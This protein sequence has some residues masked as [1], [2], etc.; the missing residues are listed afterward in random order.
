MAEQDYIRRLRLAMENGTIPKDQVGIFATDVNHE[1]DC[2]VWG[3][4]RGCDC[5]PDIIITR[6][7]GSVFQLDKDGFACDI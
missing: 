5:K 3:K 1:P 4:Q 6:P 7:N 2:S